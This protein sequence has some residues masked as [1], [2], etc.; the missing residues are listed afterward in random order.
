M[1]KID[2]LYAYVAEDSGPDDEGVIAAFINGIWFPLV[3]ADIARMVS[4]QS[5][6]L[7]TAKTT[8]K[9]VKL[10]KF[11]KREVIS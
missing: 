2:A 6:A 9:K 11:T 1:P 3:G 7:E 8:G 5:Y 4:L 10:V